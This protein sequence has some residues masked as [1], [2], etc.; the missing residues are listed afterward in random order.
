MGC[1]GKGGMWVMVGLEVVCGS[2]GVGDWMWVMVGDGGGVWELGCG[3]LDVGDGGV[4]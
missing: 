3:R 4:G 1:G 2:W